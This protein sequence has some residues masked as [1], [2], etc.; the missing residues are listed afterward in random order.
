MNTTDSGKQTD[1]LPQEFSAKTKIL[2]SESTGHI[3]QTESEVQT[4]RKKTSKFKE[5]ISNVMANEIK[6]V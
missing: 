1:R 5:E 2:I 6:L 4:V 3:I